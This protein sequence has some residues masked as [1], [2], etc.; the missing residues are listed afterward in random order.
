MSNVA[1]RVGWNN[2]GRMTLAVD[3]LGCRDLL[4]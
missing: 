3:D 1:P 2:L 4:V